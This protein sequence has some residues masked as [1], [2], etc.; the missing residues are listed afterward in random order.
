MDGP[1][2]GR[3]TMRTIKTAKRGKS[4]Q[5]N[6][7]P[8]KVFMSLNI[9]VQP[10][11]GFEF[12][13]PAIWGR[14]HYIFTRLFWPTQL[15]SNPI[16]LRTTKIHQCP[17][18][19]DNTSNKISIP[20]LSSSSSSTRNGIFK[21][22]SILRSIG[23]SVSLG[24]VFLEHRKYFFFLLKSLPSNHTMFKKLKIILIFFHHIFLTL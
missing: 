14:F 11:H 24:K 6:C 20:D 1:L 2:D 5:K 3:K 12:D 17:G 13:M 22:G 16:F 23:L 4:R 15:L 10:I 9:I 18:C 8:L 21:S 7:S 19:F